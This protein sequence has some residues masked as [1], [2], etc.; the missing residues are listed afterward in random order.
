MNSN[1]PVASK[2]IAV[3]RYHVH[4]MQV[5]IALVAAADAA[6]IS[7]SS[8]FSIIA[9]TQLPVCAVSHYTGG[10]DLLRAS[11]AVHQI[12]ATADMAFMSGVGLLPAGMRSM[13]P[14]THLVAPCNVRGLHPIRSFVRMP[15]RM[16]RHGAEDRSR[17]AAGE[18]R[19]IP[20]LTAIRHLPICGCR[21]L[22]FDG[23]AAICVL[24][25]Q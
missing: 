1:P 23:T 6:Q 19:W 24:H 15:H 20:S 7:A 14:P 4:H 8:P 18:F 11:C 2:Q 5:S 22:M 13:Q 16:L 21:Y 10:I 12:W 17:S 3:T 25:A 9:S